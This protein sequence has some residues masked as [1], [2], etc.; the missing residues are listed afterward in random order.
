[1]FID[2]ILNSHQLFPNIAK[3]YSQLLVANSFQRCYNICIQ[4]QIIHIHNF[5]FVQTHINKKA[6]VKLFDQHLILFHV[7]RTMLLTPGL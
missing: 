6:K 1:M 5:F 4:W 7:M 2:V 3:P